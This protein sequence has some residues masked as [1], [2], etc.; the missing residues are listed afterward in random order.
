[1]LRQICFLPGMLLCGLSFV[2]RAEAQFFIQQPI[3]QQFGVQTSVV[4]PDRGFLFLGGVSRAAHSRYSPGLFGPGFIG[5]GYFGPGYLGPVGPCGCRGSSYGF[6][7]QAT[8]LSVGV[9]ILDLAE[10]DRQVLAEADGLLGPEPVLAGRPGGALRFFAGPPARPAMPPKLVALPGPREPSAAEVQK[11]LND[12]ERS[13]NLG[14]EAEAAGQFGVAKLH[15]QEAQRLGS[16][17]AP[18]RLAELPH[19][20]PKRKAR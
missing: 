10:M 9:S 14:Q 13:L 1:M 5:P 8:S 17:D 7:Y 16:L 12:H 6:D 4:V 15:Y 2:G 19:A 18:L 3:V 20:V 11:K